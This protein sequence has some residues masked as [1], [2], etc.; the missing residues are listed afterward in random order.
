[1]LLQLLVLVRLCPSHASHCASLCWFVGQCG[2]S[3]KADNILFVQDLASVTQELSRGANIVPTPGA[4]PA[5]PANM[6]S[7]CFLLQVLI[8]KS[9]SSSPVCSLLFHCF[10]PLLVPFP[11]PKPLNSPPITPL[12]SPSASS[13]KTNG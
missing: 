10:A 6:V 8:A 12:Y 1:M 9:L 4:T 3:F 7:V 5:G 2:G 13:F 11:L